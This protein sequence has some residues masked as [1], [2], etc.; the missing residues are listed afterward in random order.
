MAISFAPDR[1]PRRLALSSADLTQGLPGRGEPLTDATGL[2]LGGVDE[3]EAESGV[4]SMQGDRA[5]LREGVVVRVSD[6]QRDCSTISH[7]RSVT[8]AGPVG[9]IGACGCGYP[10]LAHRSVRSSRPV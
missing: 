5:G 9:S 3:D 2:P 4:G 10:V 6:D 8:P 1:T 7:G